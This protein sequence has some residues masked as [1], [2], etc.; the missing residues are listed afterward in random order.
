[1]LM[2]SALSG[3]AIAPYIRKQWTVTWLALTVIGLAAAM[4]SGL[5]VLEVSTLE[6]ELG[7]VALLIV[8]L[9]VPTHATVRAI[10]R[11]RAG[12]PRETD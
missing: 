10:A 3:N 7:L 6:Y 12:L 4:I 2:I 9:G 8:A 11:E 1:M 5:L